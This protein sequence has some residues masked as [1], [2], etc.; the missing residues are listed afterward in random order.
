VSS[1]L[2]TVNADLEEMKSRLKVFSDEH[3]EFIKRHERQI[4]EL[5]ERTDGLEQSITGLKGRMDTIEGTVATMLDTQDAHGMYLQELRQQ[6]EAILLGQ[7]RSLPLIDAGANPDDDEDSLNCG[8]NALT[9]NEDPQMVL[10][11]LEFNKKCTVDNAHRI[12]A[13][14]N[15]TGQSLQTLQPG[16]WLD[17]AVINCFIQLLH[18]KIEEMETLSS[19]KFFWVFFYSILTSGEPNSTKGFN[20]DTVKHWTNGIECEFPMSNYQSCLLPHLTQ[21]VH[22]V[23][24]LLQLY[25]SNAWDLCQSIFL[26]V[27]GFWESLVVQSSAS[28]FMIH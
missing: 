19:C 18:D 10:D 11:R 23:F 8:M 24:L 21:L 5:L 7:G 20:F 17:D 25:W 12:V 16:E 27:I 15:I 1:K 4:S 13:P 22:I 6:V 28:K 9:V 3:A 14:P 26:A 2:D